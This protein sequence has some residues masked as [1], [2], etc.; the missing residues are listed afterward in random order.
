MNPAQLR[1]QRQQTKA[2]IDDDPSTVV[3][4]PRVETM[5][6]G[7]HKS[8]VDGTP[9]VAQT[10]KLSELAFDQRPTT[11][12]NGVERAIDYHLIGQHNAVIEVGDH[13]TAADGTRYEVIGFTEGWDYMVKAQVIRHVPR[14]ANP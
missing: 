12:V 8:Y 5:T 10:F 6:T 11:T 2:L 9:R 3:L 4:V 14:E 7:G 1:A 13:W